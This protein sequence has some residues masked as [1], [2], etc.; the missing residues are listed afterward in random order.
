MIG[1]CATLLIVLVSALAVGQALAAFAAGGTRADPTRFSWLAPAYGIAA[2]LVLAGIAVRLPGHATT[3]A[4]VLVL[5][6]VVAVGLPV[7][8]DGRPRAGAPPSASRSP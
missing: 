3:A 5:A 8:A 4:V 1:A 2:L 7:E 6:T